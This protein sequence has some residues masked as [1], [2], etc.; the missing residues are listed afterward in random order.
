MAKHM[1]SVAKGTP[2]TWDSYIPLSGPGGTP[3][4]Y[5]WKLAETSGSTATDSADSN[6]GGYNGTVT[7]D[8]PGIIPNS[9]DPC[10]TFDGSTGY[11]Q[12]TTD[13]VLYPSSPITLAI[14]LEWNHTPG[15]LIGICGL[16]STVTY[17][18]MSFLVGGTGD[19][20]MGADDG[21]GSFHY[22]YAGGNVLDG[23]PH[24]AVFTFDPSGLGG[25][26]TAYLDGV[27]FGNFTLTGLTSP[28][29]P[30]ATCGWATEGTG[31]I[32]HYWGGKLASFLVYDS[33]LASGDVANLYSAF[34]A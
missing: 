30:L 5:W 20:L 21:G 17:T 19:I 10:P 31:G 8:Q 6:T 18:E 25:T 28:G 22:V 3:P 2:P 29:A 33:V 13:A 7:L 27:T 24:L 11:M 15:S 34:T 12:A 9:S 32:A 4:T 16:A 26:F 23:S 14:A 1:G